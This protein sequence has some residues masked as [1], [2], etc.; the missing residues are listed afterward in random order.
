MT[1]VLVVLVVDTDAVTPTVVSHTK[2]AGIPL[3]IE[4]RVA[5]LLEHSW[6]SLLY[7]KAERG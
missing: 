1:V 6:L 3:T 4:T 7:S 2:D 5:V